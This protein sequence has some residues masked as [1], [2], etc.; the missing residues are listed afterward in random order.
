[1]FWPSFNYP[2][3]EGEGDCD[4]FIV[5]KNTIVCMIASISGC[6]LYWATFQIKLSF[7]SF[8]HLMISAGIIAGAF[9][10]LV[11]QL[12]PVLCFGAFSVGVCFIAFQYCG[13]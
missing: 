1:M 3:H 8:T 9:C 12:G 10:G 4:G 7:K 5:V 6:F 2:Y 11:N 13:E